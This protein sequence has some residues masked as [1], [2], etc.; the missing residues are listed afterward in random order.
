MKNLKSMEIRNLWLNFFKE[1]KHFIISPSSLIPINDDSLLWINSGVA[2]LKNFFE[3]LEKPP[4]K[5]LAN[6]QKVIRTNDI[7]NVGKTSRHHTMFE[8]LGNFSIGDYFKDTAI[9]YAYEFL[10]SKKWLELSLENLFFT[11]F[12]KDDETYKKWIKL[13]IPKNKIFKMKERTNFWD[14]GK[15]PSG[16]ST[17]IFYDRGEKF[18]SR[19]AKELIEKNIENDRYVEIW[20][21]VFSEFNN[22]GNNNYQELPQKN[23]DTGAG[24]ERIANILQETP[25]NFETDL[26]KPIIQEIQKFT[27]KKYLWNYVPSKLFETDINQFNI[28]SK[29]KAIA[30][31][32]RCVVFAIGDGA[33]P[34]S[35]GRGYVLRRLIRK[36][37]IYANELNIEEPFLYKLVSIIIKLMNNF[38][39][40]LKEKTILISNII[41][42]EEKQFLKTIKNSIK[43][44]EKFVKL[45]SLT[46]KNVFKLYETYGLPL[47]II[48][49]LAIQKEIKIDKTKVNNLMKNFQIKSKNS[50]KDIDAMSEQIELFN[51]LQET[52]FTGYNSM[53]EHSIVVGVNKDLIV[54]DK[55]PF[56]ATSGGQECDNG[57]INNFQVNS[58]KKNANNV[59]IHKIENHNLKLY[60]K[61]V[62][63][64]NETR[65]KGL[66]IHHSATHLLFSALEKTWN[67]S[68]PQVGS[69]VEQEFLR[70]DF[71]Y[72]KEI[73]GIDI[74]KAEK[75][76]NDWIHLSTKTEIIETTFENAKKIGATYL[77]GTKYGKIVRVVKLNDEVIDLCGGTHVKNT[78]EIERI[79]IFNFTK[80]GSGIYRIEAVA[81]NYNVNK[82]LIEIN[83]NLLK[84]KLDFLNAKFID[85]K[86]KAKYFDIHLSKFNLLYKEI[87][88]IPKD[89]EEFNSVLTKKINKFNEMSNIFNQ[90]IKSLFN[91][92]IEKML[93][94][95]QNIFFIDSLELNLKEINKILIERLKLCKKKIFLVY[96]INKLK[97]IGTISFV[98]STDLIN[99]NYVSNI[100]NISFKNDLRG[101]GNNQLYVFGGKDISIKKIINEV[102]KWEF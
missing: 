30:D 22:D 87:V 18:D 78:K 54:L 93:Q 95:D 46:P 36:A 11:V 43:E 98:L 81:G 49:D 96:S 48:Y 50:R 79:L 21:I 80:K 90:E 37:H 61:V 32:T 17:E 12:Y 74:K 76:A 23:I 26:F 51:D 59:I 56:Y 25:T 100:K 99:S 31:F 35:N 86:N 69:K 42:N 65:R 63:K 5:R 20:N 24:L 16:P 94:E 72:Q 44:F 62:A 13:G 47:E 2:T 28:N 58:V 1:K 77:E 33:L 57:T 39:A 75:I 4:S 64:V 84:E 19:K 82:K 52:K 73:D 34:S 7:E 66:T 53:L 38:Y 71:A 91:K 41:K 102:K 6:I 67:T 45:N 89:N 27:L 14:M 101:N 29:F 10:T 68:V 3:G 8:M 15:G 88:N 55:T 40:E 85:I 60:D 83:S 92:K 9:E 70:F 97:R